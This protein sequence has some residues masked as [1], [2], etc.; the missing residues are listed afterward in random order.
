MSCFNLSRHKKELCHYDWKF[1]RRITSAAY[2][3]ASI[4]EPTLAQLQL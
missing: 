1:Q 4:A 3:D 2:I